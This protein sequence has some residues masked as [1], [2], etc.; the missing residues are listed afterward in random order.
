M[1]AVKFRREDDEIFSVCAHLWV[2][3]GIKSTKGLNRSLL[4]SLQ[5]LQA[6]R[7]E[8]HNKMHISWIFTLII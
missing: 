2:L 1:G 4:C 6:S 7:G 3:K 8:P 5:I